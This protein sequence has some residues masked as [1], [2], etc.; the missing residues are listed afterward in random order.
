MDTPKSS[1]SRAPVDPK[2]RLE[3]LEEEYRREL[4]PEDERLELRDTVARLRRR[5][6]L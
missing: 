6:G 1:A 2:T 3:Q 5:L 4:M